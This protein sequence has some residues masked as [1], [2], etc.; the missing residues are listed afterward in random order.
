MYVSSKISKVTS[1]SAHHFPH[2]EKGTVFLKET[3]W[4]PR[5]KKTTSTNC[6]AD[7][8]VNSSA[9][10]QLIHHMVFF[11]SILFYLTWEA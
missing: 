9:K 8:S 6:T 1:F 2:L 11:R 4:N 5:E 3:S 10:Q 7:G